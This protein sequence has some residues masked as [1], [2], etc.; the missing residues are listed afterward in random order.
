MSLHQ[1]LPLARALQRVEAAL[2]Q[3]TAW[4]LAALLLVL[5]TPALQAQLTRG[6]HGYQPERKPAAAWLD[7]EEASAPR[8]VPD[9]HSR[10]C[11]AYCLEPDEPY[12]FMGSRSLAPDNQSG[13]R[14]RV[15][16]PAEL[17]LALEGRLAGTLV[18]S[19]RPLSFCPGQEGVPGYQTL[20]RG[21]A[22]SI[23]GQRLEGQ[24]RMLIR[25]RP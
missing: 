21:S 22:T 5:M 11:L 10:G 7:R 15:M 4:V 8:W 24:I 23:D 19:E 16:G 3:R 6:R 2:A 1:G 20:Y 14:I 12:V 18:L 17:D 25:G 13:D 9:P